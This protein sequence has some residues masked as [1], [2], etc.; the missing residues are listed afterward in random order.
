MLTCPTCITGTPGIKS[1]IE[2]EK[3]TEM[4]IRGAISHF[5]LQYQYREPQYNI[6]HLFERFK[7]TLIC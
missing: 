6:V 4:I 2:A 5:K 3:E 1:N 7:W